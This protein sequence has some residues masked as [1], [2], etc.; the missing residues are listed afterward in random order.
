MRLVFGVFGGLDVDAVG[1][2]GGGAEEAGDTLFQAVLV[3][4]ELVLAAEALLEF[5]AAHGTF[6]V[7]IV[8]D[9]GRL[10]HLLE[11]DAHT[12]G[13]GGCVADD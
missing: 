13:N 10:E 3:A 2:A 12:L 5:G 1:G 6:A 11:G 8:F 9:L 7:G 4:L